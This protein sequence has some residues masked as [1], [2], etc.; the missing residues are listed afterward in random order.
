MVFGG[1]AVISFVISGI[2]FLTAFGNP[3]KIAQ[4]RQAFLW[5]VGGVIVGI[6]AYSAISVI[7][8]IF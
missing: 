8:K 7:S 6:F 4:A 3:A 1:I 5:G 2:N